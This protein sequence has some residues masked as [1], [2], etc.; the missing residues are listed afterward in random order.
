MIWIFIATTYFGG[1]FG[2]FVLG[3]YI[4]WVTG[5]NLWRE[6]TWLRYVTV[7]AVTWPVG[8]VT[9]RLDRWAFKVLCSDPLDR[10]IEEELERIKDLK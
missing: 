6:R 2:Y 3:L 10:Q 8:V 9:D 7:V 1:A 5:S 4:G